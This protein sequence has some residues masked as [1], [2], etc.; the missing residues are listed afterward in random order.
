MA[1][2]TET[3]TTN[4]IGDMKPPRGLSVAGIVENAATEMDSL[5]GQRY[6]IPIVLSD[7]DPRDKSD[8][9]KLLIINA[10]LAAGRL[11]LASG[12]GGEDNDLHAYAWYLV[13]YAMSQL[14]D[15]ASGK[16]TLEKAVDLPSVG[17][18]LEG[19]M[20]VLNKDAYSG[21]DS[22]Y[23]NSAPASLPSSNSN[24]Y[25]ESYPIYRGNYQ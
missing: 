22:F 25:G 10:N 20:L 15:I 13:K 1:Y 7:V 9:N 21:V 14:Q 12:A 3:D 8:K 6:V 19:G 23:N 4:L 11:M 17:A 18:T 5:L 24:F 2:C 16:V